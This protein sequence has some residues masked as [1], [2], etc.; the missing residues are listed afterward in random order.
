MDE[1]EIAIKWGDEL[2]FQTNEFG[3]VSKDSFMLDNVFDVAPPT[4][5]EIEW[6]KKD[7]ARKIRNYVISKL[8]NIDDDG[9]IRLDPIGEELDKYETKVKN[10]LLHHEYIKSPTVSEKFWRIDDEGKLMKKFSGH[11]KYMTYKT[12]KLNAEISDHNAKIHWMWRDWHRAIVVAIIS[13][14]AGVIAEY[15]FD[16]IETIKK[17]LPTK[18]TTEQQ[19]NKKA[20][21]LKTTTDGDSGNTIQYS[22]P[23]ILTKHKR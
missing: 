15:K 4:Q 17:M 7:P 16:I 19:N 10:H 1:N 2:I 22:N 9:T 3:E 21:A 11:N 12:K 23:S 18:R 6:R 13:A 14:I 20:N 8:K 5:Q